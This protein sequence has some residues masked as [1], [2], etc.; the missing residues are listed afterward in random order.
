MSARAIATI[1][2][3]KDTKIGEL[4]TTYQDRAWFLPTLVIGICLIVSI[5]VDT[6][7]KT[8]T[9][10]AAARPSSPYAGIDTFIP[11]GDVL[12]PVEVQNLESLD[13]LIGQYGVVD[14]YQPGNPVAI[15]KGLKIIRS[16]KDPSEFSV[17]VP[18]T[19]SS[20]IISAET[21]PFL[22]V[23]QNPSRAEQKIPVAP[24]PSRI[25]IEN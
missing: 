17:L 23:V 7:G 16:P 12:L 14:L 24:K 21:K 15:A 25:V 2:K 9:I 5:L 20:T 3:L 11:D 8:A 19:E 6:R 13:S 1:Q 22:V 4:W 18:E 10:T